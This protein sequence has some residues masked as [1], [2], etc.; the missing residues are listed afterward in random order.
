MVLRYP[1]PSRNLFAH[2]L[3]SPSPP[4]SPSSSPS[5][6]VE[7]PPLRRRRAASPA[8]RKELLAALPDR[9]SAPCKS[10]KATSAKST[11]P[12]PSPNPDGDP[13]LPPPPPPPNLIPSPYPSPPPSHQVTSFIEALKTSEA[14]LGAPRPIST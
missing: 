9:R 5:P 4:P 3:P 6:G 13:I 10:S 1:R 12:N 14:A 8:E 7:R 2:L 11:V